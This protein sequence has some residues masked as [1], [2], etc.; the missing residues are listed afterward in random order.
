MAQ[1]YINSG[2]MPQRIR[3]LTAPAEDQSLVPT[4]W[5][6]TSTCT[7]VPGHPILLTSVHVWT[8]RNRQM[9]IN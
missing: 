7:P 9:T 5:Q 6:L 8:F 2:E 1:N 3:T 4:T